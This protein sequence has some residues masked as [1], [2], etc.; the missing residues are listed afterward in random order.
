[1]VD[2]IHRGDL[3]AFDALFADQHEL[4]DATETPYALRPGRTASQPRALETVLAPYSAETSRGHE[5]RQLRANLRQ[6][7]EARPE[8][9]ALRVLSG[10]HALHPLDDPP[11]ISGAPV[12][13]LEATLDL[14]GAPLVLEMNG[15]FVVDRGYVLSD[16]RLRADV[17]RPPD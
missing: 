1:V 15:V 2:A 16:L 4:A 5:H 9:L 6:L 7:G 8:V 14:D 12:Q 17:Q 13:D 3:D 11:P 10:G